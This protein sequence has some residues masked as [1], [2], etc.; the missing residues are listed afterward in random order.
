M[1]QKVKYSN[2]S[3]IVTAA[4]LILFVVGIIA[5]KDN[6]EA[7][8]LFCIILGLTTMAGLYYCPQSVE[9]NKSGITP[10]RLMSNPKRFPTDDIVSID[11][12][13]PSAG[14]LKLCGSG[15]FFGYYGYF[16]DIMI[17]TYFGYYGSRGHCFL[18]K[19]KN[20]KQYVI[21]CEDPVVLVDYYKKLHS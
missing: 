1:T 16:H 11:T 3:I 9:V 2:Y 17:G 7:Q 6:K 4:I 12:F 14:G 10:H 15:G 20:S 8:M 19:L 21:G 18:I 5:L 13:Y